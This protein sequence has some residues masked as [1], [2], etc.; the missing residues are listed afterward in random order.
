MYLCH[1]LFFS[2]PLDNGNCQEQNIHL[3]GLLVY[4]NMD[5]F[6][7]V[8]TLKT[9]GWEAANPEI[10]RVLRITYPPDEL[11]QLFFEKRSS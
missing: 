9:P 8:G 7:L 4:L 1:P 3:D 5:V 10:L 6:M 2:L 11:T